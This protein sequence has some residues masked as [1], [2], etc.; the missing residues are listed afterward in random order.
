MKKEVKY[1]FGKIPWSQ[2][3][4]FLGKIGWYLEMNK[5]DF[6]KYVMGPKSI[7]LVRVGK[8]AWKI[9]YFFNKRL[10]DSAGVTDEEFA[11]VIA[12]EMAALRGLQH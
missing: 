9:E 3:T 1:K 6:K 4:E 2:L 12:T 10:V 8:N 11:K 7:S 5:P